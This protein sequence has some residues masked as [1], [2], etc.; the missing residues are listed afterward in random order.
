MKIIAEYDELNMPD[1]ALSYIVNGDSS[2]LYE[3]E[4]AE[5]DDYMGYFEKIAREKGGYVL[6]NTVNDEPFFSRNPEFGLACN[7]YES[8]ILICK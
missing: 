6:F 3:T 4:I 5:I 8:K 2:G 1:Y 7:C